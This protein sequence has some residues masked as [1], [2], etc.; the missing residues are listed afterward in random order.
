MLI[1]KAIFK[2]LFINFVI[3]AFSI[4]ILLFMEKF[5]RL[6][7]IIMGRWTEAKDIIK[8]FLYLQPSVLLL[9]IPMALLVSIF[10]T[11]GRML[12]DNE[13]VVLKNSGVSF[14]GVSKASIILSLF[15]FIIMLFLSLYLSPKWMFS[16]KKTLYET[17]AKKASTVLEEETFSRLFK[18]T[19]VYVKEIPSKGRFRGIF[20]YRELDASTPPEEPMVIS[21]EEGRILSSPEEGLIKL[22]L[23]NG[24]VH[25]LSR[26]GASEISFTDYDFIL[27]T[28]IEPKKRVRPSEMETFS[29]WQGRKANI[30]WDV[31]VNR[32]LAIPFACIIFGI[33]GPSLSLRMGK[34][35]RLGGLSFSLSV[36][37]LYY[38]LL[39]ASE[40]LAKAEKIP[41]FWG[42]WIPN[43]LFSIV[44]VSSF[45]RSY[46]DRPVKR[47]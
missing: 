28:G 32:R 39:I 23:H 22:I 24:M 43:I 27:S 35:G 8:I 29:L 25:T 36:L 44:A 10:L 40:G 9:S 33:L 37:I 6:T 34:I 21:A 3:A 46:S 47:L 38:A 26:Q 42:G 7:G 17:I 1:Q 2:E 45:F 19:V 14:F 31:E 18:D 20:V 41:T 16:F 4:S 5:V 15:S 11:Y 13:I 12:S 30:H